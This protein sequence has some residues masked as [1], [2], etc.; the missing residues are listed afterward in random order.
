MLVD[1]IGLVLTDA[2]KINTV[3]HIALL[4]P[5]SQARVPQCFSSL[6]SKIK[7]VKSHIT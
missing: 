7:K 4:L 3:E 2:G 5:S 1:N 6:I